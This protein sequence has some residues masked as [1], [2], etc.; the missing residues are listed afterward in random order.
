MP[1]KTSLSFTIRVLIAIAAIGLALAFMQTAAD[2]I[3]AIFLA[4]I[5]VLVASPLLH[6]LVRKGAPVWLSFVLTLVAILAA[7]VAFSLVMVVA[8]D[9]FAE[10]I[11]EYADEL[12][13]MIA[14]LQDALSSL[15]LIGLE[16]GS[17]MSF[18]EP[19]KIL[20]AIGGFLTGLV[21]TVSNLILVVMLL[22][23]L[24]LEAFNAPAKLADEIKAGNAYLQRYFHVSESLRRYIFITTIVGLT[25]GIFDT[26][27]FILLGV[28]FPLLWGILAFLMSYIPTLGFW[29]AA[30]P[31]TLLA[32]L[33]SG[34]ATAA[35]VFLGVVLINGFA[36][37][38]V[39]PKYM[40][41]GLNLSPFMIIFS[42]IFWAA[43][44]GPL[45]AIL[46]VPMTLLFKEL[47]LEADDQNR[48]I[49]RLMSSKESKR[50]P[51]DDDLDGDAQTESL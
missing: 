20:N 46:G 41:E 10:A 22:I 2:T 19:E 34:P 1:D 42:V 16:S 15:G 11:P 39:K 5:I 29:L 33:E 28:S 38:V 47:V 40:G 32:L 36:E 27:W 12:E 35:L 3:N 51:V 23:F 14:S 24:L 45:G 30:I 6:S 4:W 48:W 8:V 37:N 50:I 9:R 18:I 26:I 43:V 49:A 13:N 7:F 17:I 25:T 31:P 21:G 44:L